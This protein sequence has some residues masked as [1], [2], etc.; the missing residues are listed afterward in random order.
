MF[1]AVIFLSRVETAGGLD[2]L[3]SFRTPQV[4]IFL[5]GTICLTQHARRA[6]S[7]FGVRM[8]AVDVFGLHVTCTVG[9][10]GELVPDCRD[11][12]AVFHIR[13]MQQYSL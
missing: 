2:S 1:L 4:Q 12:S 3:V 13:T 10:P 5:D 8:M 6:V 7:S 9:V 11:M